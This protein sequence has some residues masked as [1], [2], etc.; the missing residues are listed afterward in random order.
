[1]T[2]QEKKKKQNIK[3]ITF[4]SKFPIFEQKKNEII[5]QII[6]LEEQ[7]TE[8]KNQKKKLMTEFEPFC[9]HKY[10]KKYTKNYGAFTYVDC[11]YCGYKKCIHEV[12][13]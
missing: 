3:K 2:K 1:M 7:L 4:D 13:I 12:P 10:G 9:I 6:T 11:T 5:Q 8:A